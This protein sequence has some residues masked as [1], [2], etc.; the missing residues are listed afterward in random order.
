MK[1]SYA[2]PYALVKW[3]GQVKGQPPRTRRAFIV[4]YDPVRNQYVAYTRPWNA[5]G[6]W[7][8]R[9]GYFREHEIIMT[10]RHS[11]TMASIKRAKHRLKQKAA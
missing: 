7:T 2:Y 9:P 11:P 3:G 8:K 6:K 4:R 5:C 10:W 1:T